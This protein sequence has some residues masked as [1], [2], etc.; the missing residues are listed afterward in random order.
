MSQDNLIR[1]QCTKCKSFNYHTFR[2]VK[3]Q[4]KEKLELKKFCKRCKKHETHKE[5]SKK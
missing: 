1:L 4:D 3:R 2:N 5:K